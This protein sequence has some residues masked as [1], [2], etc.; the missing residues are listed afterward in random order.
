MISQKRVFLPFIT[1]AT[2]LIQPTV[3]QAQTFPKVFVYS[4]KDDADNTACSA[5][6]SS[7]VAA[8]QAALRSS[9]IGVE[10]TAETLSYMQAYVTVTVVKLSNICAATFNL[11]FQNYQKIVDQYTQKEIYLTVVHC[12]KSSIVTGGTSY[13]YTTMLN[14]YKDMANQCI[15]QYYKQI[16]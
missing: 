1:G 14:S 13:L 2:F 11:K 16:N 5:S 8:V 10:T 4:E 7:A 15:S 6:H 12:E 3:S 9:N